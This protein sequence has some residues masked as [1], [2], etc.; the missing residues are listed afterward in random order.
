MLAKV[1]NLQTKVSHNVVV[2]EVKCV[3]CGRL[4]EWMNMEQW[5]HDNRRG[6]TKESERNVTSFITNPTRGKLG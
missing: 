6:K 2:G 4:I 5:W 1:A 3:N